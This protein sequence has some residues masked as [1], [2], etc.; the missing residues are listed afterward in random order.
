MTLAKVDDILGL[1]KC[2][3]SVNGRI[4]KSFRTLGAQLRFKQI[5]IYFIFWYF[6]DKPEYPANLQLDYYFCIPKLPYM[7]LSE[8]CFLDRS[9]HVGTLVFFH[10]KLDH[11]LFHKVP[12]FPK[13]ATFLCFQFETR[14]NLK[15][16]SGK[17]PLNH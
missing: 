1:P 16:L 17:P 12:N 14:G 3:L 9:L 13:F 2:Q 7:K 5:E 11:T 8:Y 6:K 15:L 4:D 10:D